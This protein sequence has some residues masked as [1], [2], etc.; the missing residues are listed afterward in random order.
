MF[1]MFVL[2]LRRNLFDEDVGHR[3]GFHASTLTVPRN[4]HRV[5]DVTVV[6]TAHLIM[7][8]DRKVLGLTMPVSFCKFFKQCCVI[9]DCSEIFIERPSD[10][11]SHAQV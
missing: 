10:L 2:K 1:L 5:L 11:L 6:T 4:V 8:P 9:I 3:F 7:W